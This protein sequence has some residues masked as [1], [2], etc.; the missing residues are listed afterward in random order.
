MNRIMSALILAFVLAVSGCV[1][2]TGKAAQPG[3]KEFHMD[4]FVVFEDEKPKP[5]FSLKEITVNEGDTVKLYINVTRGTH[6][7][8]IDEFG[9]NSSTPT[10]Q[11]TIVQ[12]IADKAGEFVYYCNMPGHRQAGH[13]GTLKV[14]G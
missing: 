13:W 10:G 3:A 4:S 1:Q 12:F 7:F 11:V 2:T 6:D 5:Q 9:V 8:K 14:L